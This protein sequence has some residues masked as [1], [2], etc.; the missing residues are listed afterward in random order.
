MVVRRL[1]SL[2]YFGPVANGLIEI[3][4]GFTL[5]LVLSGST[6]GGRA[7]RAAESCPSAGRRRSGCGGATCTP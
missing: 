5:I 2:A 7:G 6:C 3:V 1:H 4:A